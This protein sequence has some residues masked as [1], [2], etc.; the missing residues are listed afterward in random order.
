MGDYVVI[1][2]IFMAASLAL[3]G[4]LAAGC[5]I[6]GPGIQID[7]S[8]WPGGLSANQLAV[9]FNHR[10]PATQRG[11]VIE[12]VSAHPRPGEDVA[13]AF[14]DLNGDRRPNQ[15]DEPLADCEPGASWRCRL[16]TFRVYSQRV[17]KLALAAPRAGQAT[18]DQQKDGVL[19]VSLAAFD[20]LT[21]RPDDAATL[22]NEADPSRCIR[23]AHGNDV[24]SLTGSTPFL[25]SQVQS[26]SMRVRFK[27]S[28]GSATDAFSVPVPVPL[29]FSAHA[30][31]RNDGTLTVTG[32]SAGPLRRL[33]AWLRVV[34]PGRPDDILW[35]SEDDPSRLTL[36][37]DGQ[38]FTASIPAP[39]RRCLDAP[40]C[41][42][43]VQVFHVQ[44]HTANPPITVTT[45]VIASAKVSDFL[46]PG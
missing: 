7:R 41:V 28:A 18:A 27:P 36:G 31:R 17:Q 6:D 24:G 20:P 14:L 34:Q 46:P 3:A 30:S 25:C 12:A 11:R 8:G 2:R 43:G 5:R 13:I 15:F 44:S 40:G 1:P 21:G 23:R 4:C 37:A 29:A 33:V 45:E 39:A 35:S 32:T 26:N 38:T 42:F 19:S 16:D 9:Q 22:C 10:W